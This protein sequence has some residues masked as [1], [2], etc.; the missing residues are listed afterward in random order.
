[1]FVGAVEQIELGCL[2]VEVVLQAGEQVGVFVD[3]L[4]AE[5]L[6]HGGDFV[7]E[8]VYHFFELVDGVLVEG[9]QFGGRFAG[10]PV[11]GG[12]AVRG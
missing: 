2:G 9:S 6:V 10:G 8:P 5:T 1:M 4:V 3:L 12:A 7:L 11:F